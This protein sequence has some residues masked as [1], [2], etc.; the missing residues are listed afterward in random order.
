MTS[1]FDLRY[2]NVEHINRVEGKNLHFKITHFHLKNRDK[3]KA[4]HR[5]DG[6]KAIFSTMLSRIGSIN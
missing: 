3:P 1:T 2:F 5:K 4:S 6:G